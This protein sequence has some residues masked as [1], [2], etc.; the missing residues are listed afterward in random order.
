MR[1][2]ARVC[3]IVCLTR[4]GC[5]HQREPVPGGA[6]ARGLTEAMLSMSDYDHFIKMMI[7]AAAGSESPFVDASPC[8]C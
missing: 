1:I 4:C 7:A 5:L 8:E 6:M 3:S 2:T